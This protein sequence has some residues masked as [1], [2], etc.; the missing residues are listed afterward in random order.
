MLLNNCRNRLLFSNSDCKLS[1]VN[2]Y[3]NFKFSL[4]YFN[5]KSQI[6]K[7]NFEIY[8][9]KGDFLKLT[10]I[11]EEMKMNAFNSLF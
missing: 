4:F 9:T 5:P 8:F 3:S 7:N 1:D 11:F 10:N 6:K 2:N